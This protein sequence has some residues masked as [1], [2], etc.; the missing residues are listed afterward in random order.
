MKPCEG[1]SEILCHPGHVDGA[2][3]QESVYNFQRERELKILT[4]PCARN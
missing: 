4:N 1:M 2:L 3:A